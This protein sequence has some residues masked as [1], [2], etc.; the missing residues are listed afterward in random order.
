MQYDPRQTGQ[1]PAPVQPTGFFTGIQVRPIIV[2]VV[3]DYIAT[4]GF[5]YIYFFIYLAKQLS[6]Q[7]EVAGEAYP[8]AVREVVAVGGQHELTEGLAEDDEWQDESG[9]MAQPGQEIPRLTV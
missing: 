1:P 7:G 2:G 3:V 5:T 9:G 4:Y 6:K 8:G